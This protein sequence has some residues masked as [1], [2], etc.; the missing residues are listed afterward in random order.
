MSAE[1]K[2]RIREIRLLVVG[3]GGTGSLLAVN[4]AFVGFHK[5]VICES[6]ILAGSNLN[7][8]VYATPNDIGKPKADLMADYIHHHVPEVDVE[9]VYE[10]FPN[11][12]AIDVLAKSPTIAVG[13]VDNTRVRVELDIACR[14]F[15]RTLVDLGSGFARKDGVIVSSGG[16]VLISRP[17][18]PCLMCLGFTHLLDEN[19]YMVG[20]DD[21]PQPSL[22]LLNQVAA[23]LA[24]ECLMNEIMAEAGGINSISYSR[25]DLQVSTE[26]LVGEPDCMICG[27]GSGRHI[28]S[29]MPDLIESE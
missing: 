12:T 6:D 24:V 20:P 4:A 28:A 29:V 11:G 21:S 9:V 27:Y 2:A 22:L 18:G 19:N 10:P 26:T 7:R 15:G 17:S 8:F 16:Q 3:C 23:A 25:S 13:C 14:H 1:F 5:I